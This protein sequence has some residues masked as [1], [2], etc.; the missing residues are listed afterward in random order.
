MRRACVIGAGLGGL[1]LAIRLQSAGVATTL[2]EARDAPGGCASATR[3]DKFTFDNG[4]SAILDPGAFDE[5]WQLSGAKRNDD[6]E[7]LPITPILRCNWPDGVNF[8]YSN[9]PAA[10]LGEV[11]RIAPGDAAGY[12][13]YARFAADVHKGGMTRLGM[14]PL[15]DFASTASVLPGLFRHQ[16]WRSLY[17]TVSR[18]VNSEKLREALSVQ[19]LLN[20]GNPVGSGAL[21]ALV[22]CIEQQNGAWWPKGGF[23]A[24]TRAMAALFERLGGTLR[25]KDPV[26]H[27]HTIGDRASELE[28]VSGWRERFDSVASNADTVHTY[29]DL[30]ATTPRGSEMARGLSRKRFG[31]GMFSV[32]FGVEG[33]WPG[34]P[35]R[36]VL[37]AQRYK[38]LLGDIFDHGVLPRDFVMFLDHPSVTD[39]G[40]APRGKSTFRAMIPVAHMGK[41]PID[42]EQTGPLIERRIIEEVG[43]R[44]IPDLDDRIVTKYHTT[45][46][47]YALDLNMHHGSAFGLEPNL[48]QTALL[49]PHNR[50]AKLRNV[51]LVGAGTHPGPGVLGA[52]FSAK[53]TAG[54]MLEALR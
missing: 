10:V 53:A 8:D 44:L 4:P 35:H 11:A 19:F 15:M 40:L 36:M 42:W 21:H 22:H 43:R 18:F 30:L 46:R 34:I 48:G 45:P 38:D 14:V 12:E 31:P 52:V 54:P 26:L 29:R 20:G 27:I 47:H 37:F 25:L 49:R 3:R 2:V 16:A 41:L 51:F 23:G 28:C 6:I 9:D 33:S 5:L 24:L 32:H 50:D 7:M 17:G 13:Q 1:A 39:P